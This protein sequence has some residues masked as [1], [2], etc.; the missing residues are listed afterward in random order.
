MIQKV[1]TE[2]VNKVK[3]IVVL[4]GISIPCIL[5]F[6]NCSDGFSS[7]PQGVQQ[8]N[9]TE[10]ENPPSEPPPGGGAT[11]GGSSTGSTTGGG[12]NS[13]T[14]S[15]GGT[16]GGSATGGNTGELL[17]ASVSYGGFRS[18]SQESDFALLS[19]IYDL[20]RSLLNASAP[21]CNNPQATIIGGRC[22]IANALDCYGS[23]GHSDFL[24]RA[25][26][27]G[28]GRFVAVGGWGH[29]IVS[30]STDGK[31][32]SPKVDLHSSLNLV[33]GTNKSAGWLSGITFGLNQFVAVSGE[34]RLYTSPDGMNWNSISLDAGTHSLRKIV[35]TGNGFLATGDSAFWAFSADGKSWSTSGVLPITNPD[36]IND[37]ILAMASD[38]NSVLGIISAA[39]GATRA[40]KLNLKSL[41]AGW[42]EVTPVPTGTD[43][44]IYVSEKAKYYAFTKNALYSTSDGSSWFS[45]PTTLPIYPQELVY[46]A[47]TFF[48]TSLDASNCH[49][50]YRS[51]DALTWTSQKY[52]TDTA[53]HHSARSLAIGVF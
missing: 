29:G 40:F 7:S 28:N 35:F 34:G 45:E 36:R 2:T 25:V 9:S 14:S 8:S 44:L 17:L 4:L 22:C 31:N 26:A 24:Y 32:W 23:G 3:S 11:S 51:K 39:N 16:S 30:V 41:N 20:P 10:N 12:G 15:G 5:C 38:Q 18:V 27:F 21:N 53:G 33:S 19:K 52:C 1:K 13:G 43:T 6:Q 47:G 42:T 49:V 48:T 46:D 50:V 37:R